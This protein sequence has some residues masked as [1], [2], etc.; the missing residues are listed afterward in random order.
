MRIFVTGATGYIGSAVATELLRAG[1]EVLGLARSDKSAQELSKRNIEVIRGDLKNT[2]ILAAAASSCD[3]VIHAAA[4]LG[5]NISTLDAAA[6]ETMLSAL[7][8]S[9]KTF[10]YTSGTWMY[11]STG[12]TVADEETP[13]NPVELTTWRVPIEKQV[14]DAQSWGFRVII[15]RPAVVYGGTGGI[16]AGMLD[17]ARKTG[18]VR[19]VGNGQNRWAMIHVDDLARLY[20]A[21]LESAPN[22][23]IFVASDGKALP[24]RDI[25]QL[26]SQQAGC[27]GSVKTW[28]LEEARK[29]LGKLADAL[30][31][32]QQIESTKAKQLLNWQ[33][34]AASLA[35]EVKQNLSMTH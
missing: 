34:H 27:P 4:E 22:G 23:S 26:L 29:Q 2:E 11:G 20:V 32:D 3:A 17:D 8:G 18:F 10:I 15:V 13:I 35:E 31:I 30:A 19:I 6:V 33:P 5:P 12:D 25:A 14:L 1:H 16:L 7:K 28:P 24:V 21:A 9:G